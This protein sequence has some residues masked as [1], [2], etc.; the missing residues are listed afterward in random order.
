MRDVKGHYL[1]PLRPNGRRIIMG[2]ENQK[3][4]FL[5]VGCKNFHGIRKGEINV[6]KQNKKLNAKY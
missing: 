6:S 2:I 3:S 1:N 4:R 5:Q